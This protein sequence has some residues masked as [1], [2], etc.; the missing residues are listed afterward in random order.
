MTQRLEDIFEITDDELPSNI[1]YV[2]HKNGKIRGDKLVV[3]S[4][5]VTAKE[6]YEWSLAAL[7]RGL[8]LTDVVRRAFNELLEREEG[9]NP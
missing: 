8:T 5:R 6:R 9:E 2:P 3:M 7:E 1:E 4:F